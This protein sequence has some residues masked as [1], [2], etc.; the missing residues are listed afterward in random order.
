MPTAPPLKSDIQD[1][2]VAPALEDVDT[3]SSCVAVGVKGAVVW[4]TGLSGSGKTTVA[5]YASKEIS[6]RYSETPVEHLDGDAVRK[7]LSPN[8][9]FTPEERAMHLRRVAY[10]A[11]RLAHH[12]VIV[13]CSFISPSATVRD[14]IRMLIEDAGIPF[15]E[16]YVNA[17]LEV[18]EARDPK[19]LYKLARAGKIANFTGVSAP[20]DVP[21]SPEVVLKTDVSS[22]AACARTLVDYLRSKQYIVKDTVAPLAAP[23]TPDEIVATGIISESDLDIGADETRRLSQE[24]TRMRGGLE[25]IIGTLDMMSMDDMDRYM[26]IRVASLAL[27]LDPPPRPDGNPPIASAL[28][29]E[30]DSEIQEILTA[31]DFDDDVILDFGQGTQ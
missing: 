4:L 18:C 31:D 2:Q 5:R 24:N 7:A 30:V 19:G 25:S 3:D 21:V 11:Q 22:D 13:L 1:T 12:G 8:L 14:E 27:Q 28:P 26:L 20:Y 17:P 9:G 15:V 10:L 23:P 16:V 29:P 6:R